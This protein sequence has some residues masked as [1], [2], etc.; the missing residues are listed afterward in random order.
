MV[1]VAIHTT[2][3]LWLV[4]LLA[5]KRVALMIDQIV[6]ERSRLWEVRTLPGEVDVYE[7]E[8]CDCRYR[9]GRVG[10]N[11]WPTGTDEGGRD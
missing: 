1:V 5:H 4:A 9:S 6:S 11:V 2:F 8:I 10:E 3:C 7:G